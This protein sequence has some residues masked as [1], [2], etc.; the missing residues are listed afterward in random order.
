M[1]GRC[2]TE[3]TARPQMPLLAAVCRGR[4]SDRQT[5]MFRR[6]NRAIGELAR[7]ACHPKLARECRRA[8]DGGPSGT[9]F[10]T[11]CARPIC[12]FWVNPIITSRIRLP[13]SDGQKAIC[14]RHSTTPGAR[15]G[16]TS[17]VVERR[18][19]LYRTRSGLRAAPIAAP[20]PPPSPAENGAKNST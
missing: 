14:A 17:T 2:V 20:I 1:G 5:R 10:A 4:R 13:Q 19:A 6:Y 12:A 8:K 11:A 16:A 18:P 7:L 9:T 15:R 3:A